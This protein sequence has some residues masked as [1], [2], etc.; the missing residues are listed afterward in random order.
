MKQ[1]ILL[2]NDEQLV[3]GLIGAFGTATNSLIFKYIFKLNTFLS[4]LLAWIFTWFLRK[5][6]INSYKTYKTN[7]N[8]KGYGFFL[9]I[10]NF[11]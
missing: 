3:E 8:K 6:V 2:I 7:K 9:K 11:S 1:K 5:I 10:N 4:I